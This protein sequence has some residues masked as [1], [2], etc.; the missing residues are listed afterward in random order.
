MNGT[1]QCDFINFCG[2]FGPQL[3]SEMHQI[4]LDIAVSSQKQARCFKTSQIRCFCTSSAINLPGW[5]WAG[6]KQLALVGSSSS[7]HSEA[8]KALGGSDGVI[9]SRISDSGVRVRANTNLYSRI[10][11]STMALFLVQGIKKNCW[12]SSEA[13]HFVCI[14]VFYLFRGIR[15]SAITAFTSLRTNLSP[16]TK[17]CRERDASM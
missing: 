8:C 13:S 4:S 12:R 5:R 16:F 3:D 10:S 6:I 7:L 1:H 11:L 14:L 15:I 2:A 17:G 9:H